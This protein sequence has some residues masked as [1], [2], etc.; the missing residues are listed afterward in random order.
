MEIE[1]KENPQRL[2][3]ALFTTAGDVIQLHCH[4]PHVQTTS[5]ASTLHVVGKVS[6]PVCR[7]AV[8]IQALNA[9]CN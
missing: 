6:G 9:S 7:L 5:K 2:I 4:V 1:L 3:Q 8:T